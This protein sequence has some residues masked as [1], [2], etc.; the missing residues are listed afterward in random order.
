MKKGQGTLEYVLII[1]GVIL[2]V[3]LLFVFLRGGVVRN[4]FD[5]I[6]KDKCDLKL[7]QDAACYPAGVWQPCGQVDAGKYAD[8]GSAAGTGCDPLAPGMKYC[9]PK[10][11]NAP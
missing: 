6:A 8:C 5:K 7:M 3:S 10:P 9:G 4:Q 1:A 2:L 11:E